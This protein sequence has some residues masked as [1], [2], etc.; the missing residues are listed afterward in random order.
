MGVRRELGGSGTVTWCYAVVGTRTNIV[1]QCKDLSR[2]IRFQPD[3]LTTIR[4]F[5]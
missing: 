1:T 3:A 4:R 2:L 5:S